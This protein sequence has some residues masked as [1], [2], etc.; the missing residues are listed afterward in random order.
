MALNNKQKKAIELLVYSPYM[1]QNMIAQEIG[2]NRI[3][4]YRWREE[5]EEFKEELDK[6]IKKRWKAAETIAVN[7]MINLAQEGNVQAAKY[8]LDSLGYKPTEKIEAKVDA[9]AQ[10]VFVDDLKDESDGTDSS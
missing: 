3:T 8:M 4:L 7:T 9:R 1:S 5:N 10:V 2:V 6:A